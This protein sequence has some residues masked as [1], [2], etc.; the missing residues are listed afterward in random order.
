MFEVKIDN[1]KDILAI[2]F[3]KIVVP[4]ECIHIENYFKSQV[5]YN[6]DLV[7]IISNKSVVLLGCIH[8]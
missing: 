4:S 5:C 8:L 2:I 7:A 1:D 3:H 6:K